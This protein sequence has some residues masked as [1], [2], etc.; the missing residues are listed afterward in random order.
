M[1][2]DVDQTNGAE[3]LTR[4]HLRFGWWSLLLFLTLGIVLE[5]LHG[6]KVQWYLNVSNAVRRHM[7]ALAHAHG[8]LLA[9]INI[10]FALTVRSLAAEGSRGLRF[11][12]PCL[13]GAGLALPIGFFLGG[14][15][16]HAGDPGIG[17]VLLVPLGGLLLASGVL[18]VGKNIK[19]LFRP[20][21]ENES[22]DRR[23][24]RNHARSSKRKRG[25]TQAP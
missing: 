19:T 14:I 7:L 15:F 18:L 2:N 12:S 4:R 13:I 3:R 8:T 6:F 22:L 5:M 24:T 17:T 16:F 21:T 20:L 25:G 10:A 23:N 1:R 9:L 11:A